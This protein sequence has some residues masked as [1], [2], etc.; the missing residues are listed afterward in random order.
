VEYAKKAGAF[1][2]LHAHISREML[3][4]ENGGP[5]FGDEILVTPPSESTI[6]IA[7]PTESD[8]GSGDSSGDFSGD[9]GGERLRPAPAVKPPPA[10]IRGSSGQ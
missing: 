8:T 1:A 5:G 2:T 10:S 9:S 3:R 4:V 7:P 6:D